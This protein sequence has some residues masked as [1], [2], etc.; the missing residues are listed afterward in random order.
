MINKIEIYRKAIV[1]VFFLLYL[2]L[3]LWILPDYGMSWDEAAQRS[4][5]IVTFDYLNELFDLGYEKQRP[6]SNFLRHPARHYG[7]WF[8]LLGY[9]LENLFGLS[10]DFRGRFLMRHVMVFL[11]FWLASIFFYKLLKA[12]FKDWKMALLGVLML[13]L[14][15]RI[16]AHSFFNPKD[17]VLLSC[18]I[19]SIY[20]LIRF[21]QKKSIKYALLHGIACAFVV[22]T[23]VPGIIIPAFTIGL[24][25]IEVLQGLVSRR[26]GLVSQDLI[27]SS[28]RP[29]SLLKEVQPPA[30][31]QVPNRGWIFPFRGLKGLRKGNFTALGKSGETSGDASEISEA[32][33]PPSDTHFFTKEGSYKYSF[34]SFIICA[35]FFTI[36]LNPAL[37]KAPAQQF[38][39]TFQ[40]MA[41]FDWSSHLLYWGEFIKGTELPWH[42]VPS[43]IA[44]TTP[45]VYLV[46]FIIGFV[47]V[48]KNG[49]FSLRKLKFWRTQEEQIDLILWALFVLPILAV[50]VK[51]STL[52]DG[53]RQLFF[54]YP[55]MIGVALLGI[56]QTFSWLRVRKSFQK[57]F[58][59]FLAL[60]L[61]YSAFQIIK[62]HP[63]QYVYFNAF[64]GDGLLEKFDRDYWGLSYRQA[65]EELIER[66]PYSCISVKMKNYPGEENYRFFGPEIRQHIDLKYGPQ[67]A[68]FHISNYRGWKELGDFRKKRFP[69][70]NEVFSIDIQGS[71]V[72]GVYRE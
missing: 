50:I 25:L 14:T 28:R 11:L 18:Y 36:L 43:W 62:T 54:V 56:C 57:G 53:W 34:F 52:Y 44:I 58:A 26:Y 72:I 68:A 7:T 70:Q 42:Y 5:G 49:I 66:Y 4:H 65:L 20:T 30:D 63:F 3:G 8:P 21:V 2:G 10:D 9:G 41:K 29:P 60:T 46:F 61:S 51:G 55:C 13:I 48:L 67:K 22:N 12:R 35:L 32:T 59:L 31:N 47:V 1:P 38:S 69:Y 23:R 71:R 17:I 15:P 33:K 45:I 40:S 27:G 37:W 64:A 19:I 16:F 24:V 6:R 39:E